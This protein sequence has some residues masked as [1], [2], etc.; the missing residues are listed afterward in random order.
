MNFN[1][2]PLE[3][4]EII[5]FYIIDKDSI[6]NSRLVCKEWYNYLKNFKEYYD[7]GPV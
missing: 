2:L 1:N 3:L 6:L 7:L 5:Y 4:R